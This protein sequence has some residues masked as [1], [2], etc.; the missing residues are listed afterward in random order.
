[1]ITRVQFISTKTEI[2]FFKWV[3]FAAPTSLFRFKVL[4]KKTLVNSK[5][6][7]FFNIIR[8]AFELVS[9]GRERKMRSKVIK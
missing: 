7:L 3:V 6:F 8:Y 1:M 5:N 9:T 4:K 2:A